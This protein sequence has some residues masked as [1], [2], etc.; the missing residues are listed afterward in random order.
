MTVLT[1]PPPS[2]AAAVA[3]ALLAE[4]DDLTAELVARIRA[5]DRAYAESAALT[6]AEI[7]GTVRDNLVAILG[8]LGGIAGRRAQP[9]N[10]AGRVKAE[11]GV[12]LHAVLHA[13]RLGGRVLWERLLRTSAGH[14]TDTLSQLG[15][16]MWRII[17]DY[18]GAAAAAYGDYLADQVRH[19]DEKRRELFRRLLNGDADDPTQRDVA[20]ALH[21]P[22][23]GR[24]VVVYAETAA[25]GTPPLP[26]IA[27]RLR[28]EFIESLWITEVGDCIGL[29]N[30]TSGTAGERAL[31]LLSEHARGRIGLS[32][33]FTTAD[34][35][36]AALREAELAGRCAPPGAATVTRY[37]DDA[38]PQLLAH[39]PTAARDLAAG[40][41]GAVLDLPAAERDS[42]LDTLSLW[43]ECGGANS[44]VARR[45]HY[46]RNTIHIRLRRL[47]HLTGRTCSNPRDV[48][49]LYVALA[50]A[51]QSGCGGTT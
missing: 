51:R 15:S 4:I 9:A 36:G 16:D 13:Y 42:L 24:F 39:A 50:A 2:A 41:L 33:T 5:D 1:E 38:I 25:D 22:P 32:R 30:L 46:H 19:V 28:H 23:V 21:L 8:E 47:E 18:S 3:R 14:S 37:G 40:I 44:E 29:L 6:D 17:D 48:A 12:P 45:L 49:E 10:A 20:R 31:A 7:A 35:A 34:L 27:N 11:L 26:D 43:F